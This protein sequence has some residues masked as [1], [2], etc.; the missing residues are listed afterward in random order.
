MIIGLTGTKA[1]GKSY[2]AKYLEAE[3]YK[4]L[5]LSDI[6]R[7]EAR[8]IYS[9]PNAHDLIDTGNALRKKYGPSVLAK[10]AAEK[11]GEGDYVIDGIR[12]PA[13]VVYLRK[14]LK[15][16]LLLAIDADQKIRFQRTLER[17]REDSPKTFEEFVKIDERDLGKNEP[18]TGQRVCDTM[19]MADIKM[20]NNGTVQEMHKRMDKL[21]S[22]LK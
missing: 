6:V 15:V 4:Y 7:D 20:I 5:S 11:M 1:S 21:L 13:E 8:K 3:G 2:A 10:K 14:N 22:K 18:K 17:A 9:P 19:A 12:N 16:F